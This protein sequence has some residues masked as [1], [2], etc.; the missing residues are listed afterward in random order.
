MEYA[1]PLKRGLG[2]RPYHTHPREKRA[3]FPPIRTLHQLLVMM[4]V[5]PLLACHSLCLPEKRKKKKV[6]QIIIKEKV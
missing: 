4:R 6:V 3:Q 1:E 2:A 5:I